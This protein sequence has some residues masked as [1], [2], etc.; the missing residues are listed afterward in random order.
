M[1][2]GFEDQPRVKQV[3]VLVGYRRGSQPK[4]QRKISHE[5]IACRRGQPIYYDEKKERCNL[6]LT[7][8]AL[9]K[10]KELA[11]SHQISR[12]EVLERWLR[13]TLD[14]N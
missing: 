5:G 1:N 10:L 8:T 7:P 12:S 6:M 13:G 4:Y 3:K 9:E 11:I 14:Q 2:E